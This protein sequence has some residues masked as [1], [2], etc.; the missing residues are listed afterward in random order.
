[1]SDPTDLWP[2]LKLD[3]ALVQFISL[4]AHDITY[5]AG[6]A[7]CAEDPV[8]WLTEE[9]H[10]RARRK[11]DVAEV[12][13]TRRMK[14]DLERIS[15]HWLWPQ[16]L[17]PV[18]TQPWVTQ[19][20]GQMSFGHIRNT[21]LLVVHTDDGGIAEYATLEELVETWSVD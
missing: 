6:L 9:L 7:Q 17:L 16:P 13:K 10:Q 2:K 12:H 1:M 5:L 18:K 8:A 21:N 11:K 20:K 15:S 14:E 19:A 3:P 4:S